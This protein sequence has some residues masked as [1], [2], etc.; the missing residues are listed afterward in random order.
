MAHE[1]ELDQAWIELARARTKVAELLDGKSTTPLADLAEALDIALF[2]IETLYVERD[3][4]VERVEALEEA[5]RR[6]QEM[7]GKYGTG[8]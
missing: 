8:K 6:R 3:H 4:L 1:G 5:E 2:R 7:R